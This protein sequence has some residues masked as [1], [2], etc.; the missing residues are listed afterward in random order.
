MAKI[1]IFRTMR[2]STRLNQATMTRTMIALFAS[3]K[4][5]FFALPI[6]RRTLTQRVSLPLVTRNIWAWKT[7]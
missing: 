5:S 4:S 7:S 6:N 1:P 3:Y 2:K